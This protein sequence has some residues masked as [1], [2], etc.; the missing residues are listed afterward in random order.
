MT[1]SFRPLSVF[2]SLL[3]GALTAALASAAAPAQAGPVVCTT[4]LE[5]PLPGVVGAA[6]SGPVEVTRCD[7]VQTVPELVERRYFSYTAPFARAV[8][9]PNQIAELFGIA[10]GGGDG[11]R[12]MGLGFTDQAIIWDST[13]IQNTTRFLLD[14]QGDPVPRRTADVPNGFPTSIG[15]GWQDGA[16][17]GSGGS[18]RFSTDSSRGFSGAGGGSIPLPTTT[19]RGLW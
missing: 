5:A 11:N 10:M 18:G 3:A 16:S 19:V 15:G 7:T 17:S 2:A 1:A 9:V 12:V 8:S 4:T 14:Q 13:A 6:P